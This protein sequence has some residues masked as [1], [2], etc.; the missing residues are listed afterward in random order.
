MVLCVNTNNI[1]LIAAFFNI[2]CDMIGAGA[3]QQLRE[4]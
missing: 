1:D 3:F 2:I 4:K